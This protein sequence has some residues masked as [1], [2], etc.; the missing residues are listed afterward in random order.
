M[1][2][3]FG[4]DY[5]PEFVASLQAEL[6]DHSVRE[7]PEDAVI[8]AVSDIHVILPSRAIISSEVM[9]A[10]PQLQLIQQAGIGTDMVDR[11]AARTRGIP[12]ANVPGPIGGLGKAVAETALFLMIGA[13][14]NMAALN[15]AL[16]SR[17]WKLPVGYSVF[18]ARVC[19][20][21]VGGI[22]GQLA[23]MLQAFDCEV[24]GV[25][26]TPDP[27]LQQELGLAA[28]FTSDQLVEAVHGCRFLVVAAPLNDSTIGLINDDVLEALPEDSVVVNIARGQLIDKAA[29]MT[30][31]KSGHVRT[32]GLDVFWE[33]PANLNDPLFELD[34][35]ATPH[36]PAATDLYIRD[37]AAGAAANVRRL[38]RGEPLEWLVEAP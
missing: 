26:Q 10:A 16:A 30:V 18:G 12:V 21:G 5:M 37:T 13:G 23:R 2:I 38:E 15:R 3:L 29:L 28:L 14:R 8:N 33:E 20:V 9:D 19:I 11:A 36:C 27:A 31:L 6:P 35:F 17:D 4:N 1:N 25:K 7:A 34:V 22:G 24:V 32:A